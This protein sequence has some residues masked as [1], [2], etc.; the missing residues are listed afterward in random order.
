[1]ET[2]L[3]EAKKHDAGKITKITLEIGPLSMISLEQLKFALG[4]LAEGTIAH[5]A[6]IEY[7]M[8]PLK[9][10]CEKGH[11]NETVPEKQDFYALTHIVCPSCGG[12]AKPVGGKECLIKE[13]VAE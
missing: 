4:I 11:V 2:V 3:E 13:I 9:I 1:M 10:V 7:I 5:G 8:L 6:V 12:K